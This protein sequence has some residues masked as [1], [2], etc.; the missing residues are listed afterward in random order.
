MQ[1]YPTACSVSLH[2]EAYDREANT[3]ATL[4]GAAA[5]ANR[6]SSHPSLLVAVCD[7]GPHSIATLASAAAV[8]NRLFHTLVFMSRC[9]TAEHTNLT[10]STY[11]F[12][13]SARQAVVPFDIGVFSGRRPL[14]APAR[15]RHMHRQ[16]RCYFHYFLF[17][18]VVSRSRRVAD[19][20]CRL[21]WRSRPMRNF[22]RLM[23]RP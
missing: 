4:T 22:R 17:A 6:F 19:L 3:F 21:P 23:P 13:C 12:D 8:A 10:H 2:V 1:R 7:R 5:V 11:L 15:M 14:V 9:A 16:L 20:H 18:A